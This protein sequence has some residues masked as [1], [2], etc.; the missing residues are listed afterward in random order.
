MTHPSTLSSGKEGQLLSRTVWVEDSSRPLFLILGSVGW[1]DGAKGGVGSS[2]EYKKD[3]AGL[4]LWLEVA[5]GSLA[6]WGSDHYS[7]TCSV[8]SLAEQVHVGSLCLGF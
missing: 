3:R 7:A 1:W 5:L 2:G 4:W 8:P 6:S